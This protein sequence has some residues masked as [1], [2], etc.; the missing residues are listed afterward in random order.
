MEKFFNQLRLAFGALSQKQVEGIEILVDATKGMDIKHRAYILATAW[1]ETARTMQP[2]EEYGKGKGKSYGVPDPVTGQTY[3]GRGY[4]QLT[5]KD[6]YQ[7]A[8][9][10]LKAKGLISDGADFVKN[11]ALVMEPNVA[12]MIIVWGMAEGWFTGKKMSDFVTY[13]DMRRVVNGTDK[14]DKIA[15]YANIFEKALVALDVVVQPPVPYDTVVKPKP[16]E[17]PLPAPWAGIE[18]SIA[19]W[20]IGFLLLIFAVLGAWMTKGG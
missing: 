12:A 4:V 13:K 2:I 20:L 5:W 17:T 15:E 11:P 16:V 8:Q 19:G 3:Y 1:H 10:R 18:K 6:N 14:A 7:K 9:D